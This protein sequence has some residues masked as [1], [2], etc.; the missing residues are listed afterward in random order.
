MNVQ[1]KDILANLG[2]TLLQELV[3]SVRAGNPIFQQMGISAETIDQISRLNTGELLTLA[4]QPFFKLDLSDR[5]LNLCIQKIVQSRNRD[6]LIKRALRAG[7]SREIMKDYALLSHNDFNRLRSELGL[8]AIRR[9][10]SQ[11]EDDEYKFLAQLHHK[12]GR[13]HK[14]S[15]RME[16]LNCL[17]YL[18]EKSNIDI[19][20][21]Y[22]YYYDDNRELLVKTTKS[23]GDTVP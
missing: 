19:N 13:D 3:K 8:E 17:V 18:A 4:S 12:S 9:R 1:D 15:D 22:F 2:L 5:T 6:D 14:V 20:R 16:H 10:P 11:I 7:A 23:D 21:I